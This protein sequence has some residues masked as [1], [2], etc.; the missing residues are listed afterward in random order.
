MDEGIDIGNVLNL[1]NAITFEKFIRMF[2]ILINTFLKKIVFFIWKKMTG[3]G[4]I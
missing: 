2:L 4:F 1:R 3:Y